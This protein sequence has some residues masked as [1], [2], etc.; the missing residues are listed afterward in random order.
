[1]ANPKAIELRSLDEVSF[2]RPDIRI[3]STGRIFDET[4]GNKTLETQQ[5]IDFGT[6]SGGDTVT[7]LKRYGLN[8]SFSTIG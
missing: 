5:V 6:F 2:R 8:G 7:I 3:P 1:L 4:I